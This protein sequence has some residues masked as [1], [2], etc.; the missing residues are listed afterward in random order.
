[1][2][3]MSDKVLLKFSAQT[4]GDHLLSKLSALLLLPQPIIL[5][6]LP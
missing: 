1:M 3:Y 2:F 5:K 4:Q 6:V